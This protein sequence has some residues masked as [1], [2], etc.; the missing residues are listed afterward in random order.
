MILCQANVC[1]LFHPTEIVKGFRTT[2]HI[3]NI[4]QV[5]QT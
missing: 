3:G 2:V 4:R 1:L 5:S